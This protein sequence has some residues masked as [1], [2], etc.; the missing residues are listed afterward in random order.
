MKTPSLG[1]KCRQMTKMRLAQ[2]APVIKVLFILMFQFSER[3]SFSES[4]SLTESKL[5]R[6]YGEL[7]TSAKG[8]VDYV[9]NRRNIL[10]IRFL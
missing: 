9:L 7:L 5:T 8:N 6:E 2:R 10:R 4:Q 3:S 1:C